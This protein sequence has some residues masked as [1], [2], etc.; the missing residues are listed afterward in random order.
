RCSTV[1][2]RTGRGCGAAVSASCEHPESTTS[3]TNIANKGAV[4]C[5][6]RFVALAWSMHVAMAKIF[7]W[8]IDQRRQYRPVTGP[9]RVRIGMPLGTIDR[10]AVRTYWTSVPS[11]ALAMHAVLTYLQTLQL[12]VDINS[13]DA[14]CP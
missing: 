9:V 8:L 14:H 12:F 11:C 6:A 1:T 13:K 2:V 5:I 3:A 10:P 4:A 7:L